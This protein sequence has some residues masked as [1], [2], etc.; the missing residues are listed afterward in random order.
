MRSNVEQ[1]EV[2][3]RKNNILVLKILTME[4]RNLSSCFGSAQ[5]IVKSCNNLGHGD[6][7]V[8]NNR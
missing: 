6:F 4:F 3:F 7:F 5:E 1:R 2:I 8:L